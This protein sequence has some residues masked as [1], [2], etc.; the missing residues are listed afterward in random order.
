MVDVGKVRPPAKPVLV[1]NVTL[2]EPIEVGS[3][4]MMDTHVSEFHGDPI[5]G[6]AMLR[7]LANRF[8][9]PK[10]AT[11]SMRSSSPVVVDPPTPPHRP[12]GY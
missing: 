9:P 10:P 1:I 12:V 3:D 2:R 4:V 8:D 11:R 5:V 7:A 6:A